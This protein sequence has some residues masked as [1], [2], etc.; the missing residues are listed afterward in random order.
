MP[1]PLQ[2]PG[3]HSGCISYT[4][5]AR[6]LRLL[7]VEFLGKSS[8]L[9]TVLLLDDTPFPVELLDIIKPADPIRNP[10]IDCLEAIL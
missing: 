2:R 9:R 3:G 1:V 4:Q 7:L 5:T 6:L 8:E 10:S